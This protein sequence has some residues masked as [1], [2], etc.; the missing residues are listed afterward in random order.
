MAKKDFDKKALE[1]FKKSLANTYTVQK[2]MESSMDKYVRAIEKLSK[3]QKNIQHIESVKLKQ[4]ETLVDL[5]QEL[6]SLLD[7][8]VGK[9]KEEK[10]E[11]RLQVKEITKKIKAQ[12]ISN[13][14][15]EDNLTNLKKQTG[16][17]TK[18]V[19]SVNKMN[20]GF[21]AVGK[22][23][24]S[25]PSLIKNGFGRLRSSGIMEMDKSIRNARLEMGL[26]SEQGVSFYDNISKAALQTNELGIGVEDLSKMQSQYSNEIGRSIQFTETSAKAM[27]ELAKGTNLGVEGASNFASEMDNL[28]VSIRDTR[29]Y[30]ED[31][32][33]SSHAMGLNTS[34]VIKNIQ[35]NLKLANKYNFKNGI[36]GLAHMA[37]L[38]TKF[39]LDM[40]SV[41]GMA[42]KLFDIEGAV[43]MSAQLQVLGGEW[44]KLADPFKLMYQAREDVD[45]LFESIVNATK[46]AATFVKET[47]EFKLS[48]MELHRLKKVADATGL[49]Y[50]ELAQAAKQA[51][52]FSKIKGSMN[53][54]MDEET[55][56]FITSM[57]EYD[58]TKGQYSI[59]VGSEP[60][61]L[62][63]LTANDKAMLKSAMQQ[64]NTLEEQ[65][66]NAMNFDDAFKNTVNTLKVALLPF[67]E[68]LNKKLMPAFNNFNKT[69]KNS[70]FINVIKDFASKVGSFVGTVGKW[71]ID[72]PF[73]S[74]VSALGL[75][76]AEWIVKGVALGK[77]F[78]MSTKGF[79]GGAGML[80][81][82]GGLLDSV[83]GGGKK[84]NKKG[85]SGGKKIGVGI[86]GML[87]GMALDQGRNMMDEPDSDI[88]KAMG[89]GGSALEGAGIGAMAGPYGAAI[90]AIA[91]AAK[92]TF[93]EYF[94]DKSKSTT[95]VKKVND[96]VI[97]NGKVKAITNDKDV[98]MAMKP[99]G[100]LANTIGNNSKSSNNGTM[101]VKFQPIKIE[102]GDIN[103]KSS[104]GSFKLNIMDDKGF[105]RDLSRKIN[106]SLREAING[107]KLNPNPI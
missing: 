34:K 14:I 92:G 23:L 102:F 94:S 20:L 36:K 16:E 80:G 100:P 61:L 47:G 71:I 15:T 11:I 33:N 90:G 49:S 59:M 4:Q 8:K 97:Q 88:G 40:G 37:Q 87:G 69:L 81:G 1:D 38:S 86:G 24:K 57:A 95:D 105:I 107:G 17:F 52:K 3:L 19:Q 54:A 10:K 85:W 50:E 63:T 60:K 18:Q 62:N 84:G 72:N 74:L 28:G 25:T 58:K 32:V 42:D 26:F 99:N 12:K 7:S 2:D 45:G 31:T 96:G 76:A 70:G 98:M 64:K 68:S 29:D 21:N 66:K 73:K 30:V 6:L 65:A 48:G 13:S 41:A 79:G 77:G 9:S 44:A 93:D 39:K 67:I 53:I 46:G 55:T 43:D 56:N 103:I 75:G 35:N 27:A 83:I 91:G 106:E 89:I 104:E 78:L 51:A 22:F 101:D 82:N 5:E